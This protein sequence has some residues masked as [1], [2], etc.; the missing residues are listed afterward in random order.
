MN[1]RARSTDQDTGPKAYEAWTLARD[2]NPGENQLDALDTTVIETDTRYGV[3][4][5]YRERDLVS[6]Y[7]L[8]Y[9]E[10]GQLEVEFLAQFVNSNHRVFD[11]GAFLGTFSLGLY[12]LAP[13]ASC[14]AVEAN[15]VS[16]SLLCGNLDRHL[17]TEHQ[18]LRIAL[19]L[20]GSVASCQAGLRAFVDPE[21]QGSFHFSTPEEERDERFSE[22]FIDVPRLG[23]KALRDRYGD[24][25]L[26]KLDI[27]G[28]EFD[29]LR[30]DAAWIR[31]HH[32][33]IWTECNE[34]VQSFKL[35]EFLTW[36]G[37]N[38][39]YFAFPAFN[40]DNHAKCS[41]SL[42]P[43][44]FEAGLL[45]LHDTVSFGLIEDLEAKGCFLLEIANRSDLKRALWLTPRWGMRDWEDRSK[46]QLGAIMA[47]Q[48]RGEKF[49]SFLE[50][51]P[52]NR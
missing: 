23:L 8:K 40:R 41:R 33:V 10:W 25:D 44:A 35:A 38:V 24:Y 46:W 16:H 6:R 45:G 13:F 17:R 5:T 32:P 3:I 7:L 43:F 11:L 47:R 52:G 27:E 2:T 22:L 39:L 9:G 42:H 48:L 14:V 49:E 29:V 4:K 18:S 36:A 26:L 31:K 34:H 51:E 20:P 12:G 50:V 21:N 15:P 1:G 28:S 19:G 30:S 37:Y